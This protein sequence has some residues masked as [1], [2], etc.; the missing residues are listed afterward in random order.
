MG[1]IGQGRNTPTAPDLHCH[2]IVYCTATA[3]FIALPLHSLLHCRCTVYCTCTAQCTSTGT[4]FTAHCTATATN[5]VLLALHSTLHLKVPNS[6]S[7]SDN[8]VILVCFGSKISKIISKMGP[9]RP[10]LSD[11]SRFLVSKAK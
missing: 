8:F 5:T 6:K 9:F 2:C 1:G 10:K 11:C 4:F 7:F 3:Q